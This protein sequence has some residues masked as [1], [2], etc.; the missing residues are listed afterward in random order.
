MIAAMSP[1]SP[2]AHGHLRAADPGR[3]SSQREAATTRP[4]LRSVALC[5]ALVAAACSAATT[6]APTDNQARAADL[7]AECCHHLDG[8]HRDQCLGELPRAGDPKVERSATNQ[9][10]YTCVAQHFVCDPATGRPTQDSAQA[11]Y[12]CLQELEP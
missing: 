8:V 5:C 10:T 4:I 1:A 12:D 6:R 2:R 7:A 11:Q 9:A 3:V